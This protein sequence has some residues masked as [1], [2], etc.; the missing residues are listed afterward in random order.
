MDAVTAVGLAVQQMAADPDNRGLAGPVELERVPDEV[1]E[2]L[3]HL[4]PVGLNSRDVHHLDASPGL[5]Y[6]DFEV[7]HDLS[8]DLGEVDGYEG[9]GLGGNPREGQEVVD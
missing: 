1:L 9:L 2:Q 3:T 4:G 6:T 5:L 7:G 8:R